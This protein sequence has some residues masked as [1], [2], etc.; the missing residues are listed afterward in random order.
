MVPSNLYTALPLLGGKNKLPLCH[1]GM[2]PWTAGFVAEVL[3]AGEERKEGEGWDAEK[4]LRVAREG[5]RRVY[6]I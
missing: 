4:V 3:G 1:T 6:G 2:I 5:A